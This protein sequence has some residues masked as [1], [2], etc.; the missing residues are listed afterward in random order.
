M[1]NEA[2]E[3]LLKPPVI[4]VL[5]A[6]E[7][8]APANMPPRL[9]PE[10]LPAGAGADNFSEGVKGEYSRDFKSIGQLIK[11]TAKNYVKSIPSVMIKLAIFLGL[12]SLS[13]LFL[14]TV[15]TWKLPAFLGFLAPVISVIIFL[16]A[17]YN[18]AVAKIVYITLIMTTGRYFYKRMRK[19]GVK[20]VWREFAS[21]APRIKEHWNEAK[22]HALSLYLLFGGLGMILSNYLSRNNKFDKYAVCFM[23]A[24][25]LA[26]TI[27]KGENNLSFMFYR[28]ISNDITKLFKKEHVV[29]NAHITLG[30][31][32]V[33]SGL[34]LAI[35]FAIAANISQSTFTDNMGYILGAVAVVAAA[36][37]FFVM[38]AQKKAA[39]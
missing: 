20:P 38:R 3:A 2:N 27:A 5:D 29:N 37:L 32:G 13:Y 15:Q 12:L 26:S 11:M 10:V 25:S 34:V 39:V 30:Y 6:K 33:A 16:T 8:Q 28:V 1:Q 18:N 7:P 17:A 9:S 14:M 22:N 21:V 35:I 31:A 19:E 23:L 36:V 24:I 4:P